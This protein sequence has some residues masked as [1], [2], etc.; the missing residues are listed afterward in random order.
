MKIIKRNKS[1]ITN[2]KNLEK[3]F[4]IKNFPIYIGASDKKSGKDVF[5]DL[6]YLICKDSGIV[7]LEKLVPPEILYSEYHSEALGKIWDEH[8]N[9][10]V[11]FINKYKFT[12]I[13]EIG[14][15]NGKIA[16][17]YLKKNKS[18]EWTIVEPNPVIK[19]KKIKV[20]KKLFNNKL[21]LKNEY[22]LVVHSHTLEHA[23]Q[24]LEFLQKINKV[25][26]MGGF[27]IF[28]IPNLGRYLLEKQSNVLNF[29]HNIYI[30]EYYVDELL[31]MSGFKIIK[32]MYFKKHSIFYVTQKI[33][34]QF[35]NYQGKN[36]YK[37][38]K[39]T[40]DDYFKYYI[41]LV[42]S[43]N[44]QILSLGRENYLFGAHVFSQYLLAQGLN[45]N[46]KA[47]LDNSKLKQNKRLYGT[48]F[49][50]KKPEYLKNKKSPVVILNAGQYQSEVK[51]QLKSINS[52]IKIIEK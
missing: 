40:F 33:S 26:M 31:K 22:D 51:K 37:V 29:E 6:N 9:K 23:Y 32:K 43:F 49:M 15:S 47:V 42:A 45:T 7:Q 19:N 8:H 11:E 46:I 50:I 39:K 3:L 20:I 17:S 13:L 34:N 44:N 18:S 14:G 25:T 4:T 12:N 27:Q 1:V 10:F 2:K 41:K 48:E 36:L 21:K 28:S 24:P 35:N 52:S 5:V 30:S 16:E 38:N